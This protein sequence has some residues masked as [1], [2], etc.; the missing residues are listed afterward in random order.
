MNAQSTTIGFAT[1]GQSLGILN[2]VSIQFF[3]GI[4]PENTASLT[5]KQCALLSA[6]HTSIACNELDLSW[7]WMTSIRS[8]T[9]P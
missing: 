3:V 4:S 6:I 2:E 9:I 1:I 5:V 8:R 7:D